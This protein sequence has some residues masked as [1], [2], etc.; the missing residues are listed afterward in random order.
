MIETLL[1]QA[2]DALT[3]GGPVIA[4]LGVASVAVVAVVLY[5][6]WQFSRSGVGRHRE[7]RAALDDWDR[8]DRAGARAKLN[9]SRSYL[10][11]VVRQGFQGVAQDRL[12]A[13]LD[14]RFA[15][16][17]GGLRFLDTVA[18]LAPLL[19]LFGTVL[20]MIEAFQALQAAGDNVDPTILAG[21]IWV[22]LLTTAA[23]LVVAMPAALALSW[24][25]GRID[26]DRAFADH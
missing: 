15:A 9:R 26:G 18:Q 1:S 13:E 14:R 4:I 11:Q 6:L 16:L 8:G 7:L 20:G 23:G 2:Q 3:L 19:G 21:G 10:A 25:D 17:D 22:A 24:L 12:R 5:K